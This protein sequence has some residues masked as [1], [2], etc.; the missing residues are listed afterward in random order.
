MSQVKIA[1]VAP[2]SVVI[3]AFRA[4]ATIAE[5]IDSVARQTQLPM[6]VIVVDDGS[7]DGTGDFVKELA[8]HYGPDWLQV[9][10]LRE[11]QGAATARNEGWSAA[12]GGFIAFLD[13]DDRWHPNKIEYQYEYMR[14][15]PD[16]ALC[17][18]DYRISPDSEADLNL[19]YPALDEHIRPLRLLLFNPLVTPSVMVR[20]SVPF[21]FMP[22]KR[23]TDDHLLWMEI[24]LSGLRVV[25]LSAPLALISKALY[26]EGGLS[27]QMWSMEKGELHNYWHLKITRRIGLLAAIG[28]MA[29]SL[30]KYMRRIF[31]VA[32]RRAVTRVRRRNPALQ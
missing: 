3:P 13:A 7:N 11:N 17:G 27:S 6:E 5:A 14:T 22:G 2:V 10:E 26:G 19:S 28:L 29:F 25:K 15:H 32:I 24:A 18:H 16:V 9:L 12:R 21:R 30:A 31:I 8:L 20:A 1:S 23:H 4:K